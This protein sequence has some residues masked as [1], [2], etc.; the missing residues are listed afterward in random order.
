MMESSGRWLRA[1]C[2]VLGVCLYGTARAQTLNVTLST[3]GTQSLSAGSAFSNGGT[4]TVT[5]NGVPSGATVSITTVTLSVGNAG[6]FNSLSLDGSSPGGTESFSL[7]LTSGSNTAS[8][9]SM[10]LTNG[11]SATFALNGTVSNTP[12]SG[13]GVTSRRELQNVRLASM[14]P[15]HAAGGASM[16]LMG[17]IALGLMAMSGKLRRRHLVMFAIWTIMAATAVGCGQ[18]GSASSDQQVMAV[19][20]TSSNGG[21]VSATGLPVDLGTIT[22][23]IDTSSGTPGQPT[24]T[25][26]Q[27]ATGLLN[28][29]GVVPLTGLSGP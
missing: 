26:S 1:M 15:G 6:V 27:A 12:P 9:S 21:T 3:D 24:A 17:L 11:Q 28:S 14:L 16:M 23:Q 4:I 13:T 8:F 25:P 5:A 10:T 2:I 19:S 29:T 18:G 7:P 22:L 20:A